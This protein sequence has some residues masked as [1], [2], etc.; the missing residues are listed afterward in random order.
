MS[1]SKWE[2]GELL[3]LCWFVFVFTCS[4]NICSF[5]NEQH[6]TM[7]KLHQKFTKEGDLFL[8]QKIIEVQRIGAPQDIWYKLGERLWRFSVW[9]RKERERMAIYI[10]MSFVTEKRMA[11]N[12]VSGALNLNVS[13]QVAGEFTVAPFHTMY[14]MLHEVWPHF[15][16]FNS[17]CVKLFGVF[18]GFH[19]VFYSNYSYTYTWFK[20]SHWWMSRRCG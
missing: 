2:Y 11:D 6:N 18:H 15:S 10:P 20:I 17:C 16:F 3:W 7:S 4:V 13:C 8:G 14:T 9:R 5:R 12:V 1:P 19:S